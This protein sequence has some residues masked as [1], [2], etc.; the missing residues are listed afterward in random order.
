MSRI[1]NLY[2]QA[3]VQG[4]YTWDQLKG[5][6][7]PEMTADDP[8]PGDSTLRGWKSR[9][10]WD[11]KRQRYLDA[12]GVVV[13]ESMPQLYEQYQLVKGDSERR[14][15]TLAERL[16]A[17]SPDY[18]KDSIESSLA[19]E[20][21]LSSARLLALYDARLEQLVGRIGTDES[22]QTWA[23]VKS[24][25][26]LLKAALVD[27]N[28]D[29]IML[30]MRRLSRLV[31]KGD[32]DEQNWE[33]IGDWSARRAAIAK[34]EA[35]RLKLGQSYLDV[36]QAMSLAADKIKGIVALIK[37]HGTPE[38]ISAVREHLSGSAV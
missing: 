8:V 10:K 7:L 29:D 12:A 4:L 5:R 11:E 38:L 32:R 16:Q 1:R 18:I 28:T 34:Q 23:D 2:E 14:L 21:Q 3:Y 24:E 37:K 6:R 35:E 25:V 9:H 17:I 22:A 26:E 36:Q 31:N 30:S 20:L 19:D 15:Q 13:A 27:G 33:M